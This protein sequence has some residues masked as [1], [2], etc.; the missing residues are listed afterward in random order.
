M[1][2]LPSTLISFGLSSS[3]G[4]ALQRKSPYD[5]LYRKTPFDDRELP[6]GDALQREFS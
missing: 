6:F 3:F 4:D 5:D 1:Q 2:R